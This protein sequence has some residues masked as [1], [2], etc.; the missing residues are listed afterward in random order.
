MTDVLLAE[1]P[2]E[3]IEQVRDWNKHDLRIDAARGM[4]GNVALTGAESRNGYR[5]TEEALRGA[6]PLYA[7]KPVFLD[8]AA[9]AGRPQERSTRDLAGT[10]VSP[11]FEGGRIRGDVQTLETDAGRTLLALAG[12]GSAAVG[13]SHV[14]LARRSADRSRVEQIEEVIS[15]DAVVFPATAA[16]F[17][18]SVQSSTS[19]EAPPPGSV[20]SLLARIDRALPGHLSRLSAAPSAVRRAGLFHDCVLL[21]SVKDGNDPRRL[22]QLAWFDRDGDLHFG[23]ALEEV[24]GAEHSERPPA[25]RVLTGFAET[26]RERDSLRREVDELQFRER[27]ATLRAQTEQLLQEAGLPSYAVTEAFLAQ[28]HEAESA[29]ERNKLIAERR[30]LVTAAGCRPP[31]S[32]ERSRSVQND[33]AAFVAAVC[34]GR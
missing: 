20:E 15:V 23:D 5:Y 30:A 12:S 27:R 22:W 34:R 18:E 13:M 3:L 33:D 2:V 14:V 28:L 8:H 24:T 11:R 25:S 4:L 32:A 1:R 19:S 6:V 21:E 17:R 16:T 10:I 29:A 9:R 31:A 7:E 26:I